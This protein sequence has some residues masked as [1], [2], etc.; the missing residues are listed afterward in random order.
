MLLFVEAAA[1]GPVGLP[2]ERLVDGVAEAALSAV[3]AA[4]AAAQVRTGASPFEVDLLHGGW[5]GAGSP[6]L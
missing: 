1:L 3:T 6:K 5:L 4:N 2:L